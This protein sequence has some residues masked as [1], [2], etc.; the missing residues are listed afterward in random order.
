LFNSHD[1]RRSTSLRKKLVAAAAAAATLLVLAGCSATGGDTVTESKVQDIIDAGTLK[2]GMV[3]SLPPM[4]MKDANGDPEGYDVDIAQALADFLGVELEIVDMSVESRI[5]NIQTGKVDVLFSAPAITLERAQTVAFTN[6]YLAA[7]TAL[8]TLADGGIDDP[9]DLAGQKIGVLKGTFHDQVAA[10]SFPDS[11]AVMFDSSTDETTA[12]RNGQIAAFLIDGNSAVYA[13]AQDEALAVVDGDF[14][15]IE[16]DGFAVQKGDQDWLNYLNLFIF[17]IEADG[18][19]EA[20]FE[21][22]FGSPRLN[23]PHLSD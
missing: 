12:L 13:A 17:Q 20:L 14:G 22:W 5:A 8:L 7:G 23:S 16:Y 18:T 10:E 19:N 1:G 21:Q 15:P 9:S 3:L 4:E 11:S 2:V 6:P